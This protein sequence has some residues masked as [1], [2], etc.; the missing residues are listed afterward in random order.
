MPRIDSKVYEHEDQRNIESVLSY[1]YDT[2]ESI[3]QEQNKDD[4]DEL[5]Y[6]RIEANALYLFRW[7]SEFYVH[8]GRQERKTEFLKFFLEHVY[9]LPIELD[10]KDIEEASDR[11]LTIFETINNRGQILAHPI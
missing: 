10:G 8:L 11:A 6:S 9:L 3:W 7:M 5:K 2:F 1:T 4:L